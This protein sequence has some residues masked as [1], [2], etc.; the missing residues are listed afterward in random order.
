MKA[1]SWSTAGEAV[2]RPGE[3]EALSGAGPAAWSEE[4]PRTPLPMPAPTQMADT[5]LARV[6]MSSG[7]GE[8]EALESRKHSAYSCFPRTVGRIS[9]PT[10]LDSVHSENSFHTIRF[11]ITQ[12]Y[13]CFEGTSI[14][15]LGVQQG[16]RAAS[17]GKV[18]SHQPR[19]SGKAVRWG[20]QELSVYHPQAG[21]PPGQCRVCV[22]RSTGLGPMPE[23]F[24]PARD[25]PLGR[26]CGVSIC[27]T[28][29]P[30]SPV[31]T[32]N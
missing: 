16:G 32:S 22:L 14:S 26:A 19:A 15:E 23:P 25:Q 27:H 31:P 5:D 8:V 17:R 3:E 10:A 6:D 21:V 18:S 24:P 7:L 12:K 2:R 29:F 9:P 4:G 30:C 20:R 11:L 1:T 28:H 13:S